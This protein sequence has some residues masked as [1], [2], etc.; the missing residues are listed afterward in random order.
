M[1]SKYEEVHVPELKRFIEVCDNAY[2][3]SELLEM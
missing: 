1:A 2:N 3:A